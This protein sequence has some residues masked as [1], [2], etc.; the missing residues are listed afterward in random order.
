MDSKLATILSVFG[1]SLLVLFS[2]V[3]RAQL[4]I[5]DYIGNTTTNRVCAD[6]STLLIHELDIRC[7]DG[8][9][10]DFSKT[11]TQNCPYGC[12]GVT[13][14]CSP[15]KFYSTAI[16]FGVLISFVLG[17]ILLIRRVIK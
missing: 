11:R 10:R 14:E 7:I 4:N 15:N 13:N 1:L 5:T 12:D 9:C 17:A 6:N 8:E 16:M 3:A 2:S